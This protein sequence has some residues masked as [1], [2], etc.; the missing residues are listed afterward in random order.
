[1]GVRDQTSGKTGRHEERRMGWGGS[2]NL[3]NMYDKGDG[4]YKKGRECGE[5]WGVEFVKGTIIV[6]TVSKKTTVKFVV[7]SLFED[8]GT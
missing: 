2:W 5:T 1:M 4:S 3:G 6:T 8:Y 7:R